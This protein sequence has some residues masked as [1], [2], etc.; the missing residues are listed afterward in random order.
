MPGGCTTR[1]FVSR[2]WVTEGVWGVTSTR[3]SF[4]SSEPELFEILLP[5][6][7]FVLSDEEFLQAQEQVAMVPELREEQQEAAGSCCVSEGCLRPS[8]GSKGLNIWE[9]LNG[10][11]NQNGSVECSEEEQIPESVCNNSELSISTGISKDAQSHSA[12]LLTSPCQTEPAKISEVNGRKV[13]NDNDAIPKIPLLSAADSEGRDETT[14]SCGQLVLP[15]TCRDEELS[16]VLGVLCDES[17]EKQPQVRDEMGTAL[18]VEG[19]LLMRIV[20]ELK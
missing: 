7:V 8:S 17:Q 20:Q 13:C 2:D 10:T 9:E 14:D 19:N 15:E 18:E 11:I 16:C 12:D 4:L 5:V 3:R 6:T 1:S